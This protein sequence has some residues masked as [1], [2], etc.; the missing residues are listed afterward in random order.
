MYIIELILR[1]LNMLLHSIILG[2]IN[3]LSISGYKA[4]FLDIESTNRS[5]D[6]KDIDT[7][8]I[9]KE[10]IIYYTNIVEMLGLINQLK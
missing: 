7:Y 4:K 9:K 3:R 10:K 1:T 5:I 2:K 8:D 6:I